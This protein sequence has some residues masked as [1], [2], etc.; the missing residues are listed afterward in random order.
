[1]SVLLEVHKMCVLLEQFNSKT[2]FVVQKFFGSYFFKVYL[3]S[4]TAHRDD[5]IT[6]INY[7]EV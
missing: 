6:R 1:M 4:F 3:L 2:Y 7:I 5:T